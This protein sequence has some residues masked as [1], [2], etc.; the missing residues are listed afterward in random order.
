MAN[1]IKKKYI[2]DGAVDGEKLK[3]VKDQS[4]RGE[5]QSGQEVD[6]LKLDQD[7]KVLL[8]GEEA[9]L[10][11]QVDAEQQRAEGEEAR[12]ESKLDQEISDRGTL[13]G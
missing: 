1:Q 3:L 8:K 6:L 2:Q 5:N 10:K 9:A 4:V 7:D 13:E 12:I 11:S